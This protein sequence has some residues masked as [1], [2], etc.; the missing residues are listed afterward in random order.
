M[1]RLPTNDDPAAGNRQPST[2]NRNLYFSIVI[3]TY[4]RLDVLRRVLDALGDQRDA[5]EHETIVI[6]DGSTDGTDRAMSERQGIVFR[7]QPN[8]GPGRARNHGVSVASGKFVIFIGDDTV[9]EPRFLAEHA[10][11]HREANDDPLLGCLGY[12][13]WPKSERV[14][15]FMNYINDYGLQFGYK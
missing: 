15:A 10:R 13:G 7:T 2:V 4:N 11:V 1:N 14:T 8:G 9:P 12:T 3:P 5:P 6:N